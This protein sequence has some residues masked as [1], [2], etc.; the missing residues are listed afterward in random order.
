MIL[1]VNLR[2]RQCKNKPNL[3]KGK[4]QI[5]ASFMGARDFDPMPQ[6]HN[7]VSVQHHLG[8]VFFRAFP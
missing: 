3:A 5:A 2:E 8:M 1:G 4:A 7:H 6:R